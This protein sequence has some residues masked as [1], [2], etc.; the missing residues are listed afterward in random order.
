MITN[1]TFIGTTTMT[2]RLLDALNPFVL[3]HEMSSR[4]LEPEMDLTRSLSAFA[5]SVLHL[6]LQTRELG[7]TLYKITTQVHC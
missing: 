5:E 2:Q 6:R 7:D 1:L 3:P 4:I